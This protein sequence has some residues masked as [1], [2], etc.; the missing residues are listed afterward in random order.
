MIK[1]AR[2]QLCGIEFANRIKAC[3]Q[4]KFLKH[5]GVIVT[6]C[7]IMRCCTQPFSRSI[8]L[9]IVNIANLNL[10]I[11]S[12]IHL[13][14]NRL[15]FII[16]IVL[17]IELFNTVIRKPTTIVGKNHIDSEGYYHRKD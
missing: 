5:A 3:I 8:S 7:P 2:Q 15:N 11:S 10:R 6:Y 4:A 17:S 12:S 16:S 14:G 13:I 9:K 1:E